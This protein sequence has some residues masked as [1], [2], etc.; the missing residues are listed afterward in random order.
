M[1][2]KQEQERAREEIS[3]VAP[4][5]LRLQLPI[6]MPGLG[7]VNCYALT[8]K[9]GAALVDPGLPGPSS[10]KALRK[11]LS[12]AGL[13]PKAVHTVVVTHSHPEHFG[14][15]GRLA[16]EAGADLVTHESFELWG[17]QRGRRPSTTS[18]GG[19]GFRHGWRRRM[20]W[21]LM[22]GVGHR[23]WAP[24][25][26]TKK[27]G[28]QGELEL[29]GRRWV[30]LHTPGHTQDHLCLHDPDNGILLSGDHVL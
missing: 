4:G 12:D 9:R 27:V 8:D 19:R 23:I 30:G 24:P 29:G 28:D 14:S 1:P 20:G 3:E 2:T 16:K 17:G 13:S 5:V 7:H 11:R 6:S 18:W 21:A 15:A 26:P 22:R 25:V 10:W